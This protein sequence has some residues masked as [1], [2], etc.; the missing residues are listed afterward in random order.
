MT[1]V[2]NRLRSALFAALKHLMF[3]LLV[4]GVVAML[5]FR[6]WYPAPY[7]LLAGG[8]TLFG[9]LVAVD[10][11]SGPL[12][13]LMVFDRRKP[14]PVLTH[15][16]TIIVL[17]QLA[18]L[19]Y[20]LYSVAQAR[21]IFLAYEGNRFRVVSMADV[22]EA[23]LGKASPEF[24][25]PGFSG[26]RL[27][28]AKLAGA[29][30][31]DFQSSVMLSMQG[32]HPAFRPERW[33]AYEAL[34]PDLQAALLPIAMLKSKHPAAKADIDATLGKHALTMEAAGYL[35]LDAEKAEP[36]NWVVIVERGSGQPKA[37]LPLDG[38]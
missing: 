18:S 27:I 8:L 21:P 25:V 4:A 35:P 36:V 19:A 10:V 23:Q 26:P 14:R 1:S 15:D 28:G 3:S 32:L 30:D 6:W 31:A 22:D 7:H 33:V 34:V 38:W 17:L 16:I 2:Q 5:V 29:G 12:L 11:V 9:I 24:Q 37:F 20:G 13:T